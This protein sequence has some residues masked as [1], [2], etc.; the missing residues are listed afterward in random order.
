MRDHTELGP[1]EIAHLCGGPERVAMTVLV[2]LAGDGRIRVSPDRHRVYAERREPRDPVETAALEVVPKVGR[3]LGLTMLMIASSPAVEEVGRRLRAE[4]LLP[5]S[6]V[7]A[8]W[9]WGRVRRVRRLRRALDRPLSLGT[10]PASRPPAQRA[11]PTANS[12]R[13]SKPTR[14]SHRSRSTSPPEAAGQRAA[15]RSALPVRP[16]QRVLRLRRLLTPDAG[17]EQSGGGS[18]PAGIRH[19]TVASGRPTGD[20]V[21]KALGLPTPSSRADLGRAGDGGGSAEVVRYRILGGS[22]GWR[23]DPRGTGSTECGRSPYRG[24]RPRYVLPAPPC[25]ALRRTGRRSRR[26]GTG[27]R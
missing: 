22:R 24:R 11:S 26:S 10:R 12:G 15:S 20:E 3:V 17:A 18:R 23:A 19:A 16:V 25:A 2:G 4:R 14:G 21:P 8:L 9:Q 7:R 6:R 13:S 27:A 5:G 1:Y